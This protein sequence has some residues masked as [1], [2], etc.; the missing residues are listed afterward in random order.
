[1]TGPHFGVSRYNGSP[2]APEGELYPPAVDERWVIMLSEDDEIAQTVA[3]HGWQAINISDTSPPFLYTCGLL[4]TFEHPELIIFGLESR[5]THAILAA[6][7]NG[8][9]SG[10]SFAKPGKYDRVTDMWPIA[11]QKVHPT[12]HE[13]Y[14]GYA[15][16]HC[17]HMGNAGGLAAMQVFWP[18]DHGR[19]PFDVG[20]DLAV[21]GSQPRLDPEV[22]PSEL[23]AFRRQFEG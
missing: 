22:P 11:V 7:V 9:R 8:L 2:A 5:Q 4:T 19:Y 20:C 3:K 18:D 6:M 23:R 15:M 1:M 16:G 13:F 12:Q 21:Y 17:R 14:L 10:Q